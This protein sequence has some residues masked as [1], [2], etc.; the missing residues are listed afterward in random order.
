M[1]DR[2][3]LD[4][5]VHNDVRHSGQRTRSVCGLLSKMAPAW[6]DGVAES[7]RKGSDYL[8]LIGGRH[9]LSIAL[10]NPITAGINDPQAC[11]RAV[12]GNGRQ[13]PH[14]PEPF[15]RG[16]SKTAHAGRFIKIYA[17]ACRVKG[18]AVGG[19]NARILA[20]LAFEVTGPVRSVPRPGVRLRSWL[21]SPVS[22]V[23]VAIKRQADERS[24]A[25]ILTSTG[26]VASVCRTLHVAGLSRA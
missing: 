26:P 16:L 9:M 17:F 22:N 15:H 18:G 13:L 12:P 3:Q 23:R 8:H 6:R 5:A 4:P 7:Y 2:C 14:T 10:N 24:C 1:F 19:S 21:R 11:H 20:L 25:L